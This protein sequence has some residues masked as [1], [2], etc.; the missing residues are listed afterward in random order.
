MN[1]AD[2]ILYKVFCIEINKKKIQM[3]EKFIKPIN[4]KIN[5]LIRKLCFY[6]LKYNVKGISY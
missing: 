4:K 5:M 6:T 1:I 3:L 2:K